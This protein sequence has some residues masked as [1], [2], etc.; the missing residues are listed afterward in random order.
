MKAPR[1]DD[2]E[3]RLA[4]LRQYEVLDTPPEPALDD[5]TALAAHICA[6]PISLISLVDDER[7]WFKSMVGL[8]LRDTPRDAS[9]CA[10]VLVQSGPLIV[11]DASKDERFADNPLV[12][13]ASGIRFYAAAPLR[14]PDGH[15]LGTLCVMDRVARQLTEAQT[16]AL[17]AL[18]RQVMT[19]LEL[20]RQ[21]RELRD[22][23]RRLRESEERFS[24]AF[25]SSATA[26]L[27][28]SEE[29]LRLAL[30]AAHMG[31][32]DWDVA[33]DRITWSRGHE[34][35]YG[36]APG[37]FGGTYEA[38]AG[39]VH[40]DDLPA[41][42]A[43]VLRCMEAHEAFE[44]EFR[45]VWPDGSVHW[46]LGRGE[47]LFD[48]EGRAVRM[49]GV[50]Q[51]ITARKAAEASLQE[52][53]AR[54]KEAQ[55]NAGI[56]S[57]RYLPSGRLIWS[58]QMYELFPLPRDVPPTYDAMLSVMHPDD[59]RDGEHPAFM[60]AMRSGAREYQAE[61]RV[62]S[63]TGQTRAL[64]SQG[65]IH[66]DAAGQV[67]EAVGTVQDITA[68]KQ[69][70][71]RIQKLNRVY[72]MLSGIN[73]TIVREKD[74]AAILSAACRI[75]VETGG[76]LMAWIGVADASKRLAVRAHAGADAAALAVIRSF[77]EIDPPT[78]CVFTARA[79][80][81][82]QHAICE[83]I[84]T[85][86]EAGL[87]RDEALLRAYRSLAVLPLTNG[88]RIV[89]TFNIYAGDTG[90]FDSEEM[91][92]LD[93]LAADISFAL[94]VHQR[95][96][97]RQRAEE[98]FRQVVENINEVFWITDGARTQ[99]LYV[100]PAYET[101]WG[102]SRESLYATPRSWQE[103]VHPEER[104]RVAEQ[105]RTKVLS[106]EFNETFRITHPTKG[107]RWIR[108][109][110]F[111][112]RNAAGEVECVV[113]F[114]GD[115]TEQ[116]QLEDQLRQAQKM[117]SMGRLAGGIAHDFNN[118]LTVINGTAD[119]A[120]LSLRDTDPLHA[121]LAQIRL[122][123]DRA[124][125]L[126]RQ[127]LA[128]SRQQILKPAVI[129]LTSVVRGIQ[130]ML[131]RLLGEDVRLVFVPESE[132]AS[133]KADP[134][135]M[136]QV[137][138]NLSINARDAMPDGGTLT[139]ETRNVQLDASYAAE[140][141]ATR[142]GPYVMVAV[143]DT[144]TGMD[145]AT[146]QRIFEPFFTTK[147]LGKGTGL[148]LST[149]YGI[150]QQSGG[151]IWVYSEPGQGSTFK[152]YLPRV[153]DAARAAPPAVLAPVARGTETV[154]LVEDERALRNLTKRILESGGYTV[155]EASDGEQALL[156][157]E[158]HPAVVHLLL[159]D[160]VMPGM[161]GRELAARVA[162]L[163]PGIK[164]LYASGYTDDAI[165]RHGVL[166]AG[167]RFISKPYTPTEIKRKVRHALDDTD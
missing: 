10:H 94:E 7:Q 144:G 23:E 62:L 136:E 159:T 73:E 57:W 137:L 43:E 121:D 165:L 81:T 34:E 158:A 68:R 92:L 167:S 111:P 46:V 39:R 156:R 96:T 31:T 75:T 60:E 112:V 118:L 106:G 47:F 33:L 142:P 30:D 132:I 105:A 153:D 71:L 110:A 59:L 48:A 82:G 122:A 147:E 160:V 146:R 78:G 51:E 85:D 91:D 89:G 108:S 135:Q 41:V 20:R 9:F 145:E 16:Q 19:Q 32:F 70:E 120:A 3:E 86:P 119:L 29:R 98:R 83:D 104:D 61:Y 97:E 133:V 40:R 127:L 166:D 65:T 164:V 124:A 161:N 24:R 17:L 162:A 87:W 79:L 44:R 45:V 36:F 11:P 157:L 131:E 4:V 152:I 63:A 141:P 5:L 88:D 101:I 126:T 58:D 35:M 139:I 115:I 26:L 150:V 100:S 15:T 28:E 54:F 109:R 8:G 99:M 49:R 143:S 102:R 42:N 50:S 123:G 64:W 55:R 22:R 76:F 14:S 154:L 138:L 95:E 38:F 80:Q 151:S 52:N 2:E 114:A 84:S 107:T 69:A 129:S 56:G 163:R 140:H 53:E 13:G 1:P 130:D 66:R 148:G 37:T 18:C 113:G 155:L 117:E 103:A 6:T 116:R 125:A 134:G 21:T 25:D 77:I 72:A 149:V 12:T 90:V 128:L 74:P 93:E 27:T 67:V